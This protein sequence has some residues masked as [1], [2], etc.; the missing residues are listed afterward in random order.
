MYKFHLQKLEQARAD[1]ALTPWP[2][3]SLICLLLI[4]TLSMSFR[5]V[6]SCQQASTDLFVLACLLDATDP[7]SGWRDDHSLQPTAKAMAKR[8]E[9]AKRRVECLVY[10]MRVF[11]AARIPWDSVVVESFSKYKKMDSD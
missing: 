6:F 10:I 1:M 8:S 3:E 2:T 4:Q 9:L 11:T 5:H 7:L